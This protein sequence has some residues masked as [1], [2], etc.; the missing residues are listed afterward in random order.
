MSTY[1]NDLSV[2]ED[3]SKEIETNAKEDIN[4]NDNDIDDFKE[5]IMYFIEDWINSNIKLFKES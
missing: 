3:I 1:W 5:S 4:Y 2:L